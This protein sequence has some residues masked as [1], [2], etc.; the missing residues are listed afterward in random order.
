MEIP[1][2]CCMFPGCPALA[3]YQL[4]ARWSDGYEWA[5]AVCFMHANDD[6]W[7]LS[8]LRPQQGAPM[9]NR[10]VIATP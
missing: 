7:P 4:V 8:K 10:H 3:D 9:T 6:L 2:L 5:R 1:A